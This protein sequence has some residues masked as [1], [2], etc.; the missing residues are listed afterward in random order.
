[1]KKIELNQETIGLIMDRLQKAVAGKFRWG[2]EYDQKPLQI[3][4]FECGKICAIG[5]ITKH[6]DLEERKPLVKHKSCLLHIFVNKAA[7]MYYSFGD[8]FYF[9]GNQILIDR[10]GQYDILSSTSKHYRHVEC[11][12]VIKFAHELD[13]LDK[14]EAQKKYANAE[15]DAK[16]YEDSYWR[17]YEKELEKEL[18]N[19]LDEFFDDDG[20]EV[21]IEEML[22]D[23][24]FN[25]DE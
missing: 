19:E 18:K 1:M 24:D 13:N 20:S 7:Q 25:E 5:K 17:N 22:G 12:S 8:V 23:D 16:D 3:K 11:I 21:S 4:K 9:K 2:R 15:K 6:R 10:K 14:A